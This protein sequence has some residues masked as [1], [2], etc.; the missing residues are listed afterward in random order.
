[1]LGSAGFGDVMSQ[2]TASYLR[3]EVARDD[4]LDACVCCWA[5]ERI[6]NKKAIRV[7]DKPPVDSRRL[8]ME[9]WR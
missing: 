5:A 7:P 9:I 8:R 3:K 6:R 4:I 1:M 2:I